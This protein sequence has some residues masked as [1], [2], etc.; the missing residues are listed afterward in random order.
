MEYLSLKEAQSYLSKS[1]S[2]LRGIVRGVKGQENKLFEG[3]HILKF[4]TLK[5]RSKKIYILKSYLDSLFNI[6]PIASPI[7]DDALSDGLKDRYIDRLEKELD[8][9]SKEIENFLDLEAQIIDRFKE[10]QES[11]K[12]TQVQLQQQTEL[13]SI[14]DQELKKLQELEVFKKQDS[15]N[16]EN[17]EE[18]KGEE[19]KES[20]DDNSNNFESL[21]KKRQDILKD[22][23]DKGEKEANERKSFFD[24][25]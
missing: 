3:N 5:N 14:K 17:I 1:E 22:I 20:P 25:L 8:N 6:T 13:T 9:K 23:L 18:V 15:I 7:N 11:L 21:N 19:V 10:L 24:F 2:T 12:R 16:T 4:D